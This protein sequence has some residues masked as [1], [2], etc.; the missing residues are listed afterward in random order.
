MP[1]GSSRAV[2]ISQTVLIAK[3]TSRATPACQVTRPAEAMPQTAAEIASSRGT[4]LR[5]RRLSTRRGSTRAL[6]PS[7]TIT[8]KM[9]LPTTLLTARS[10]EP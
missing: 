4:S 10:A 8:L 7:T 5:T 9:L 3:A 1:S 2:R 6:L